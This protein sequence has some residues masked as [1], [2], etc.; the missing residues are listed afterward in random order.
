MSTFYYSRQYIP[1]PEDSHYEITDG[2]PFTLI[3]GHQTTAPNSLVWQIPANGLAIVIFGRR[4]AILAPVY[5]PLPL[6]TDDSVFRNFSRHIS[7][8]IILIL[9]TM[10]RCFPADEPLETF[11]VC[12]WH[13]PSMRDYLA[14]ARRKIH[15]SLAWRFIQWIDIPVWI[16]GSAGTV[17]VIVGQENGMPTLRIVEHTWPLRIY[18]GYKDPT[19][20]NHADLFTGP[21]V[22]LPLADTIITT[23]QNF[24]RTQHSGQGNMNLVV[25]NIANQVS[26]ST[27]TYPGIAMPANTPGPYP[28]QTLMASSTLPESSAGPSNS[29]SRPPG[30]TWQSRT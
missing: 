4:T 14:E 12:R 21:V 11:V 5:P 3:T 20:T 6:T 25:A 26:A 13:A 24:H 28:S 19:Q 15:A 27:T 29:Q 7:A 10:S 16:P 17:R 18:H 2:H 22:R 9:G 23:T 1:R 8:M 30:H